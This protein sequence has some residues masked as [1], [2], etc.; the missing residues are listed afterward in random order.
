VTTCADFCLDAGFGSSAYL[1]ALS[2]CGSLGCSP[3]L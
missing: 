3:P 1:P 2:G